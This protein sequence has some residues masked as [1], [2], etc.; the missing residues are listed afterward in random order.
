LFH[1]EINESLLSNDVDFL[2][3]V[4]RSGCRRVFYERISYRVKVFRF[5]QANILREPEHGLRPLS[6]LIFKTLFC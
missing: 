6:T 3:S 2:D 4:V 1:K 5:L